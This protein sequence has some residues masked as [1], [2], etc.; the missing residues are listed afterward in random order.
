M[1]KK[2]LL[3]FISS[4]LL[5]QGLV[6]SEDVIKEKEHASSI[7]NGEIV[8]FIIDSENLIFVF[9]PTNDGT[10]KL[11]WI[12]EPIDTNE[13]FIKKT[14]DIKID[15]YDSNDVLLATNAGSKNDVYDNSEHSGED[16]A[17]GQG[18]TQGDDLWY[19]KSLEV[20]LEKNK[21]YYIKAELV[22]T[23]NDW[24]E[25]DEGE[26]YFVRDDQGNLIEV[27]SEELILKVKGTLTVE[28]IE[29]GNNNEAL[30][31]EQSD[32]SM[33]ISVIIIRFLLAIIIFIVVLGK[34]KDKFLKDEKE[35][36]IIKESSFVYCQF[37][38][39]KNQK[40]DNFC[41]FCGQPLK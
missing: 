11:S 33:S 10:Y 32:D 5:F 19:Y 36:E 40:K 31:K 12:T 13:S 23:S 25:E 21:N 37:C 6:F 15:I 26:G 2:I 38:G 24:L 3:F 30:P 4:L 1:V 7:L 41:N 28:K 39:K 22:G 35:G 14:Y 27:S 18:A 34:I 20:N 9:Q 29:L 17:I 8:E 16:I